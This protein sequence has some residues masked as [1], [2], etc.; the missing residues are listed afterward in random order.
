MS[1]LP[2]VAE[3]FLKV[4]LV[5]N[6]PTAVADTIISCFLANDEVIRMF[7]AR[8][9]CC[10]YVCVCVHAYMCAVCKSVIENCN[11][12]NFHIMIQ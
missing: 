7:M 3:V 5:T 6:H 11:I 12:K 4:M 1:L 9:V 10:A 2:L 8:C